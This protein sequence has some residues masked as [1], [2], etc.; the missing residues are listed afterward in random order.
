M[1]RLTS[2]GSVSSATPLSDRETQALFAGLDVAPVLAL[3]VSGGPDSTALLVLLARWRALRPFGPTLVALTVDHGLRPDSSREARAVKTLATDLGVAHRTMRWRG[4][5]PATG[6][7]EAARRARY[8]LLAEAARRA[9][10]RHLLTAHT[11]DDQA[12]TV[13]FRLARGSGITGLAGM[14]RVTPLARDGTPFCGEDK[15]GEGN[16]RLLLVRPFVD[17]P[18][19]RLI[20][21]LATLGVTYARDPSNVDPRFARPRWRALMPALAAEGLDAA[22]LATFAERAA[23]ADAAI[24]RAVDEAVAGHF[25]KGFGTAPIRLDAKALASL[26]DEV[27]LRILGR[28]IGETGREGPVRLG[29]LERLWA[30]LAPLMTRPGVSFRR[31]LAGASIALAHGR[32][33]VGTAPPRRGSGD[34]RT[35]EADSAIIK[36]KDGHS[37]R[38]AKKAK[39]SRLVLA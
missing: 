28:A 30:E 8:G 37:P 15:Y 4:R 34:K 20:A 17:V 18:K 19:D 26:P 38:A 10:A 29:R 11:R 35:N 2:I 16:E 27:G 32:I 3:A 25:Q 9:G 14:R 21:T 7:Q 23:R 33:T 24:Q 36:G 6:L 12:E 22:R 1:A 5:K 39:I 13:L 31:T